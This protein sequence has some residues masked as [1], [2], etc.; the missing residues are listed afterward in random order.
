MAYGPPSKPTWDLSVNFR[1]PPQAG[2]RVRRG[3]ET[4]RVGAESLSV[5][6]LARR[7]G[8]GLRANRRQASSGHAGFRGRAKRRHGEGDANRSPLTTSH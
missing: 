5:R 6:E 3:P 8:G 2:F 4:R 1:V 7:N